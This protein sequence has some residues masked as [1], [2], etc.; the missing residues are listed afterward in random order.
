MTDKII[1]GHVKQTHSTARELLSNH[2]VGNP[3]KANTKRIRFLA[4]LKSRYGYTN[5]KAVDELD[6]LL[7]QFYKINRSLGLYRTRTQDKH[8]P[9]E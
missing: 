4:M 6:R 3:E 5:D 7:K 1:N 9:A 8:L 2:L